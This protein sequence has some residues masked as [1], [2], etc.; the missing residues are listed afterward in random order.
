MEERLEKDNLQTLIIESDQLV[1]EEEGKELMIEGTLF[2]VKEIKQ[3]ENGKTEIIGLFDQ[4]ET[5]IKKLAS[6]L[7]ASSS[8]TEKT[9]KLSALLL[10]ITF[11]FQSAASPEFISTD[12]Y[13]SAYQVRKPDYL[14]DTYLCIHCPPPKA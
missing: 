7:A 11:Y 10:S 13:T 3:L 5:E 6:D 12:V 1:W 9:A 14:I 4:Q 2:D 8:S